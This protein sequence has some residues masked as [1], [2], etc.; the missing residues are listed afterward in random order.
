[1]LFV[2]V[3][4]FQE[5]SAH[6]YSMGFVDGYDLIADNLAHG[7]GYRWT[8]NMSETMFAGAWIPIVPCRYIQT[9]RLPHRSCPIR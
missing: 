4:L 7:N 3:P 6:I 9:R 1:M 5:Y 8:A 2:A